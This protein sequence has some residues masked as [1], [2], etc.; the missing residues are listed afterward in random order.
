M[1]PDPAQD[2]QWAEMLEGIQTN[3]P[4][5]MFSAL[6]KLMCEKNIYHWGARSQMGKSNESYTADWSCWNCGYK[7]VLKVKP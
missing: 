6:T 7:S 3:M 2:Q 1:K 4:S 5:E